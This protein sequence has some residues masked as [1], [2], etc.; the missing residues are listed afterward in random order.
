MISETNYGIRS[1]TYKTE[2]KKSFDRKLKSFVYKQ[3]EVPGKY[4]V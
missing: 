2:K 3:S 4:V 1:Q